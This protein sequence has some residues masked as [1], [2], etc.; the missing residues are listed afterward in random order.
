MDRIR[1]RFWLW[2]TTVNA[3][4][5]YGFS[6]S[7]MTVGDGLAMLGL[8]KAMMCGMLPPN[9]EEFYRV[10]HCERLLWEMSLDEGFAFEHNLATIVQ[11]HDSH[12]TVEGVLLDDFSTAEIK[13][14]AKP[15][16]L[17]AMRKAMPGDLGLWIVVYSMSLGIPDLTDYLRHV[18]G[19]SF[20]VWHARDLPAVERDLKHCN[21]LSGGLPTILGLYLY[22]FGEGRPLTQ[23]QMA[24]QLD[25]ATDLLRDGHCEGLCLLASSVLDVGLESVEFTRSW[26]RQ[27]GDEPL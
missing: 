16:V 22:D 12:P 10:S 17:K 19:V 21:E 5:G 23:A 13:R 6:P 15:S 11:L 9:E 3:L 20:W 24:S 25:S 4:S 7:E 2:G 8:N 26:L 1:D 27:H 14:G 18:D